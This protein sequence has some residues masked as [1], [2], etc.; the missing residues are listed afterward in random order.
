MS[1]ATKQVE[2]LH[3]EIAFNKSLRTA[4][5]RFQAIQLSMELVQ[6]ATTDHRLIEA[7]DILVQIG[8]ENAL[9]PT[10]GA[11]RV[12]GMLEAKVT[13]LQGYVKQ[14]LIDCWNRYF[15]IDSVE[16]S[17]EFRSNAGGI[18]HGSLIIGVLGADL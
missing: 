16:S 3:G 4:L 14:K 13:D 6:R 5:E 12:S 9:S 8:H 18:Q 2:L 11:T 15:V 17:I 7:V 10:S 1:D